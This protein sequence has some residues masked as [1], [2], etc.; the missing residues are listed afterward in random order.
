MKSHEG[1]CAKNLIKTGSNY[2]T[3]T[4]FFLRTRKTLL[5][6]QKISQ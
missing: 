2:K 3:K 6:N 5:S 4:M 1:L